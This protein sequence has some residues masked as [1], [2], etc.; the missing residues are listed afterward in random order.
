MKLSEAIKV[1]EEEVV[2]VNHPRDLDHLNALNLAIG[3]LKFLQS[4]RI[5]W[6]FS[7]FRLLPGEDKE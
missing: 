2:K 6:A 7:S 5:A 1:L 3:S 4:S